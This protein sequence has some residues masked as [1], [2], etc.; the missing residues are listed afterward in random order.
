MKSFPLYYDIYD[1][2]AYLFN[3]DYAMLVLFV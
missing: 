2:F 3:N 1:D